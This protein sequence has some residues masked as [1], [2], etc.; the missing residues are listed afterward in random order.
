MI[1][2]ADP[3]RIADRARDRDRAKRGQRG[4]EGRGDSGELLHGYSQPA[5]RAMR[6]ASMRLRPPTLLMALDR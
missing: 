6:M 5:L 4:A 2:A 1:V 3:L